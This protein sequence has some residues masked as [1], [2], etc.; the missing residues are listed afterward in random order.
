MDEIVLG[1]IIAGA[2]VLVPYVISRYQANRH[3]N[4]GASDL[5]NNLLQQTQNEDPEY[6]S[7]V[8]RDAGEAL[9]KTRRKTI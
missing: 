8:A 9:A 3:Y 2:V 7:R 1:G 5:F 4:Q 6:V